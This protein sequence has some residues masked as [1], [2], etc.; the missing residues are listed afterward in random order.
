MKLITF[1]LSF[2]LLGMLMFSCTEDMNTD[3]QAD[4]RD[5]FVGIYDCPKGST[6][7]VLEVTK[8]PDN[9]NNIIIGPYSVPMDESGKY[10][11]ATIQDETLL[12]VCFDGDEITYRE[13]E[14][15]PFGLQLVCTLTGKRR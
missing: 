6:V 13:E 15:F 12:L 14:P 10:G 11:P 3:Q 9:E 1:Y 8:D 4:F 7:V 2:M 5:D